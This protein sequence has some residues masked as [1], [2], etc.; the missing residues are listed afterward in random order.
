ME[1]VRRTRK[2][3]VY[4]TLGTRLLVFTHV[5]FPEAGIQVPAGTIEPGERPRDAALREAMEETGLTGLRLRGFLGD[6][7]RDLADFGRSEIQHRS[8][9]HV[10]CLDGAA[11]RWRHHEIHAGS[12]G[13][14][15]A[16]EFFWLNVAD[17]D[18]D[19][20]A[21]QGRF[22]PALRRRLNLDDVAAPPHR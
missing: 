1:D 13:P 16:L 17:G 14:P 12:G 7:D 6:D 3:V 22:L 18:P 20:I 21:D 5:D 2:A 19:L 8:F 10:A 11:D 9:F 15:I 4:A